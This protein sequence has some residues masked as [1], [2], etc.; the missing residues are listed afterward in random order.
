VI[1]RRVAVVLLVDRQGRILMQHRDSKA[2][3]SPN[4]WSFPG[5]KIEPHEEPVESARRELLEETGLSVDELT[6]FGVFYRPSVENAAASVEINAFCAATDATQ[7]DVV[8]GEGQA[9]V[10][11]TPEEAVTRDLGVTAIVL[12]PRFLDS[13]EY[14][15]LTRTV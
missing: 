12:L 13:E 9:M 3:T 7:D 1:E 2:R 4:Q 10:F 15:K 11:T 5:G 6:P 14:R 8:L